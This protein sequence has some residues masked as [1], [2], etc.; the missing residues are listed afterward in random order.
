MHQIIVCYIYS[1]EYSIDV[2]IMHQII[3]CKIVS[4]YEQTITT[5]EK[6]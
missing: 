4:F 3:V 6:S 2:S 1:V 5:Y